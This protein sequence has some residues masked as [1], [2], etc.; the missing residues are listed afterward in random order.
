VQGDIKKFPAKEGDPYNPG[1]H[2]QKSKLDGEKLALQYAKEGLPLTIIRPTSIY[3]PGDTRYL[4]LY[5][6]INN[7]KFRMIGNGKVFHHL[8]Y[9]DDLA[10]G[11]LLAA[12]KDEA[13][14]E[15]FTIGGEQYITVNDY[16]KKIAEALNKP[17]PSK[18][19]L[20]VFPI[21]FAGLIFELI[22]RPFGIDPPIYRRRVGF[23]RN[24]RAFDIS[25]AKKVLGYKPKVNVDEGIR[26]T[27]K[28]Y[29]DMGLLMMIIHYL[30][31]NLSTSY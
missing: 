24:N 9:V 4:K 7:N 31:I 17:I 3:G 18:W 12:E 10:E 5:K 19:H 2:Y 29:K 16:V 11:M 22:Y 28:W 21:W 15:I 27:A 14:G 23:F 8:V 25:K 30:S 26:R 13:I 6:F 1:D 20:P